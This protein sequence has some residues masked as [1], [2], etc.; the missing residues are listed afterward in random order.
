MLSEKWPVIW[1]SIVNRLG[2][3]L[4]PKNISWK[5]FQLTHWL[6]W[7]GSN[8]KWRTW[9]CEW[10]Q[11]MFKEVRVQSLTCCFNCFFSA[12]SSSV[13]KWC[14]KSKI[15]INSA[16]DCFCTYHILPNN[17]AT[18]SNMSFL[19]CWKFDMV[20]INGKDFSLR[21]KQTTATFQ[22]LCLTLRHVFIGTC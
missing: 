1:H 15:Y 22:Q 11:K 14:K 12:S 9:W 19:R 4:A 2:S 17:R 8:R 16:I 21:W 18:R 10:V 5:K 3:F 7:C 13:N 20:F 6:F